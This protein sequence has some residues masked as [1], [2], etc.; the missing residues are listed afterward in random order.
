MS[1]LPSR[2]RYLLLA[3]LALNLLL[4]SALTVVHWHPFHD[5]PAGAERRWAR[6]PDP[7]A[8]ARTLEA[9][10]RAILLEVIERHR[11]ELGEH[12]RPLGSARRELAE[13]LRR[14]PF[15]PAQ[16]DAAFQHMRAAEGGTADAMHAFM[17][18]LAPKISAAG[19]RRIAEHLERGHGGHRRDPAKAQSAPP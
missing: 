3:S 14:E 11:A 2:Y 8:L 9:E 18:D 12:F 19:R 17:L 1:A 4:A 15:D 5:A 6:V 13:A 16:M 10:D 7:R